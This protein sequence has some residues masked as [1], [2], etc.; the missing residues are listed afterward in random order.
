MELKRNTYTDLVG[1]YEG[2]RPIGRPRHVWEGNIKCIL[3]KQDGR[4][5]NGCAWLRIRASG[6]LL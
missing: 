1:K 6:K 3:K 2:K 4:T 5:G